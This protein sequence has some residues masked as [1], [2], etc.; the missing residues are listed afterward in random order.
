MSTQIKLV[1]SLLHIFF[2]SVRLGFS[3]H[4]CPNKK[5]VTSPLEGLLAVRVSSGIKHRHVLSDAC[6]HGG[7]ELLTGYISSVDQIHTDD[8]VIRSSS[9][10]ICQH[11]YL[12]QNEC[13]HLMDRIG[14]RPRGIKDEILNRSSSNAGPCYLIK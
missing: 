8:S 7:R 13:V 1:Q 10:A 6:C 11:L 9:P 3:P 4:F 2:K 14:A 5:T 12:K